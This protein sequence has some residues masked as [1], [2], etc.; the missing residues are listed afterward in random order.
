MHKVA[1]LS[2]LMLHVNLFQSRHNTEDFDLFTLD[3]V[4][5][6]FDKIIQLKYSQ[7][8]H[9][10]GMIIWSNLNSYSCFNESFLDRLILL[11]EC[12]QKSDIPCIPFMF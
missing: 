10:K 1:L 8:V 9:L 3:D 6:A 11:F 2:R 12:I 5:S 7:V 4:D